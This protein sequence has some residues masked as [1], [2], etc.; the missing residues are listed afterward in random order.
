MGIPWPPVGGRTV[1]SIWSRLIPAIAEELVFR[2][3]L[4]PTP[5]LARLRRMVDLD[6]SKYGGD[7]GDCEF[8]IRP[9]LAIRN[10]GYRLAVRGTVQ[11]T[12]DGSRVTVRLAARAWLIIVPPIAFVEVAM[13]RSGNGHIW[14]LPTFLAFYHAFG[15]FL[16]WLQRGWVIRD[17]S[18]ALSPTRNGAPDIIPKRA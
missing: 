13:L 9:R 7:F 17:F 1:N 15:C 11:P 18:D 12:N 3:E 16:C 6:R 5:A 4:E 14:T 8:V 10:G 2:S